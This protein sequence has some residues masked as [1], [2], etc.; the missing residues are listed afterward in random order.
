[1]DSVTAGTGWTE[2][3]RQRFGI[4]RPFGADISSWVTNLAPRTTGF[5]VRPG[6][7]QGRNL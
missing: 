6:W 1:M 5:T 4:P 2:P 3:T 7:D